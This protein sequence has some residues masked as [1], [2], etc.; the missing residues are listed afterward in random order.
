MQE[1][2]STDLSICFHFATYS[3]SLTTSGKL[4]KPSTDI[5]VS[6]FVK[7]EKRVKMVFLDPGRISKFIPLYLPTLSP[8]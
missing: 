4:P 7:S 5:L 6:S 8:L 3:N 1:S 2:K